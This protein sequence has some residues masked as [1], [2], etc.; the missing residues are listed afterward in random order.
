MAN[1]GR[2]RIALCT[3]SSRTPSVIRTAKRVASPFEIS[4]PVLVKDDF[5]ER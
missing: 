2:F 4:H 5:A 3:K 1:L